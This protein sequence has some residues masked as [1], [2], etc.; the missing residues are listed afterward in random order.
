MPRSLASFVPPREELVVYQ[1]DPL[2][3]PRWNE[4]LLGHPVATVFHTPEW[5]EAL[6]RTYG[7]EPIVLTT[8]APSQELTMG[9]AVC[10]V[11]SWLTG[12][13]LVSLPFSDHCEPLV[14]GME[15]FQ[16]LLSDFKQQALGSKYKYIELRP[17]SF[18]PAPESGLK[19]SKSFCFHK[20]DLGPPAAQLF[21]AFHKDCVQRKIRRAERE[22][23]VYEDG[24]SAALLRK[25]YDLQVITRRRQQLP[26]QPFAWFRNLAACMRDKLKVRLVSKDGKP[27]ASIL[28]LQFRRILVYKY[29]CSD[30]LFSNLGGMQLL[31]WRAIQDAKRQGLSEFDLG[32]SDLDNEG[33]IRFKDRLGATPATVTYWRYFPISAAEGWDT[34]KIAV[35]RRVVLHLPKACLTT[36]GSLLYRHVG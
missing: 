3:D 32:R 10:R 18:S 13:R 7:Y 23:L 30:K 27:V 9:L 12:R 5:L 28:T 4:L 1:V 20:L 2:Q 34:W 6:R 16:R 33:L 19:K 17:L 22:G 11:N 24:N 8:C 15:E 36:A 31:F 21:G 14:N 25:F 26:T 29:G 35:A